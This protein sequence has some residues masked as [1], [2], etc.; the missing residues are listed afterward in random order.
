LKKKLDLKQIVLL[1]VMNTLIFAG[2]STVKWR[3]FE[4]PY[5]SI[6]VFAGFSFIGTALAVF[7]ATQEIYRL[8]EAIKHN[9][10]Q[11]NEGNFTAQINIQTKGSG[12]H[13]VKEQFETLR[14]MFNTWIYE[15]LRS[16]VAIK[17]SADKI[18]SSSTKTAEGMGHLSASLTEIRQFFEETTET[19]ADA[20]D[21]TIQLAKSGAS[22]AKNSSAAVDS[23]Q[24]ANETALDGDGAVSQVISSMTQI[25]T[26]VVAAYDIIIHLDQA[27]HQIGAITSTIASISE[28]TNMLAL[29]AAIE[30]ARAGE[31]GRG[32]AVVSTEVRK[33]ADETSQAAGKINTLIQTVQEQVSDAVKSMNLVNDEVGRGVDIAEHAGG[34]LKNIIRTIEHAVTLIESISGDV[35]QQSK[36]TDLISKNITSVAGN[37]QTGTA[38]V[39]EITSIMENQLEYIRFNSESTQELLNISLDLQGIMKKFDQII[40]EQMLQVC[41]HIAELLSK[42]DLSHTDLIALVAK[43]GLTE[44]HLLDENGVIV[45]TSNN[46]ILGFQFSQEIGTQTYEFMQI[47]KD[48][49][50]KVNQKSA[51]RDVDGKLFKYA[52]VSMQGKRGIVQCGLEASKMI[53]FKGISYS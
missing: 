48:P 42:N 17:I 11:F 27:S 41:A 33:L 38:S 6:L 28:Q 35:K 31:H 47:L 13:L 51:F 50:L 16:A 10:T 45:C 40:G 30:S 37:L 20:A 32:F 52:G 19:L 26:D 2:I 4:N 39:Q 12:F 49:S 23:V 36:G 21:A 8:L 29:N 25:K 7:F 14:G 44:I 34:S 9:L 18:N 15:L 43:I 24:E 22:I 3:A 53:D 1:M 46:A 5:V